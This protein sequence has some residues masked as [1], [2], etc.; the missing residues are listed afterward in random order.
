[1]N[2]S[3]LFFGHAYGL[4]AVWLAI[5]Y[6]VV[7]QIL[8]P[9]VVLFVSIAQKKQID[10]CDVTLWCYMKRKYYFIVVSKHAH[11]HIVL[12]GSRIFRLS[13]FSW[14]SVTHRDSADAYIVHIST[15]DLGYPHD[16][17][18]EF[19]Q[20]YSTRSIWRRHFSRSGRLYVV[21]ASSVL[22][23]ATT[24]IVVHTLRRATRPPQYYQLSIRCLRA[25]RIADELLIVRRWYS[26]ACR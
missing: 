11:P 4:W 16:R 13:R 14:G 22:E 21:R 5:R 6:V 15:L 12:V 18:G 10:V 20:E 9:R 26:N 8:S 3:H 2:L 25:Q 23:Y 17:R 24:R 7:Q 1:M 19:P